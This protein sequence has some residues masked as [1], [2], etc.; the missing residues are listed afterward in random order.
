[1]THKERIL[2]WQKRPLSL[3]LRYYQGDWHTTDAGVEQ[4]KWTHIA[5]RNS[6]DEME[7]FVDGKSAF[8]GIGAPP[9][10]FGLEDL[11]FGTRH[12]GT[13]GFVGLMDDIRLYGSPLSD[14]QISE[15]ASG[16]RPPFV[17]SIIRDG[18]KVTL[19]WPSTAGESFVIES[20]QDLEFWQE[21][22]DAY[23]SAGETTSFEVTLPDPVPA[24]FY[25]RVRKE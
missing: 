1:V 15:L 11:F 13:T 2:K 14:K 10:R 20:T 18:N 4:D 7:I 3:P 23:P 8:V 19:T 21:L 12:N 16:T 5:F 17:I 24:E 6:G 22:T 9:V 25:Y